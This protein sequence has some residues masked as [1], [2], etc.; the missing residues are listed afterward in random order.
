M[1]FP[2]SHPPLKWMKNF[3]AVAIDYEYYLSLDDKP[4]S[5]C[6]TERQM[7]VLS[8]QNTYTYWLTRWYNTDDITQKT[9]EFIAAEI[10]ALLMCG[11][12]VPTPSITDTLNAQTY[13]TSTA[14]TYITTY[15]TW[16]D[17]GQTVA[18]IAPSLDYSTGD[19]ADIDKLLCLGLNLYLTAIV[20]QAKA[21]KQGSLEDSRDL[22]KQLAGAF[23]ALGVAAGAGTVAG[24]AAAAVVGFFGG[25]WFVLGLALAAVGLTVA[26][27]VFPIDL[28]VFTDEE[29]FNDVYCTMVN[30]MV[31]STPT[32][33]LFQGALSPNDFDPGSHAAELAT[34]VQPYLD[35][36]DSYLQFLVA[37]NGLYDV[38][39]FGI[40]PECACPEDEWVDNNFATGNQYGWAPFVSMITFANWTGSGWEREDD[41]TQIAIFKSIAGEITDIELYFDSPLSGSGGVMWAGATGLTGLQPG[42]SDDQEKWTWTG[43]SISSGLGFDLYRPGGF[44]SNQRVVRVRYKLAP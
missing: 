7:Y 23:G 38:S 33:A 36:L 32:R 42:S 22:T 1:S 17:A 27:I 35:N 21:I 5:V 16:N 29:A 2:R 9:V 43:V 40:L 30:N 24:G 44:D 41:A 6:L 31:G 8:V 3:K 39:D 12:G 34:V 18:S 19:P 13:N 26:S 15:N 20:E 11:C 14:T 10:E 25:P 4:V 28:S 37:M